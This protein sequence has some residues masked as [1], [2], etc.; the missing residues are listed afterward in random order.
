MSDPETQSTSSVGDMGE[1]WGNGARGRGASTQDTDHM[2]ESDGDED[3]RLS[4]GVLL[5]TACCT[6]QWQSTV[7]V[8]EQSTDLWQAV[9][10]H[11]C[12]FVQSFG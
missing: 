8:E 9:L 5:L 10:L 12:N 1:P 4:V 2:G 7:P 3:G 11:S 6:C